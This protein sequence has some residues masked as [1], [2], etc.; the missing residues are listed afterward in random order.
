MMKMSIFWQRLLSFLVL[1]ILPLSTIAPRAIVPLFLVF[2]L[3]I[4]ILLQMQSSENSTIPLFV[5]YNGF[6]NELCDIHQT[7]TIKEL[8]VRV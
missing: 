4:F 5:Q 1:T 3:I 8:L 7:I 6:F 2:F